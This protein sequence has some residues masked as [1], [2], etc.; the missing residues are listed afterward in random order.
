MYLHLDYC[1]KGCGSG[2]TCIGPDK[3]LCALGYSGDSCEAGEYFN[4]F[5]N[6]SDI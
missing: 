1:S 4:I 6:V 2:G 5:R 3:C